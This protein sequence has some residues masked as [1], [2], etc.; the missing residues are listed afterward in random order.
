MVFHRSVR[1]R[2]AALA[3]PAPEDNPVGRT[4]T[5]HLAVLNPK[6]IAFLYKLLANCYFIGTD[7][8]TIA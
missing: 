7:E 2:A 8:Q 5:E 4:P 3:D 6:Y 1:I